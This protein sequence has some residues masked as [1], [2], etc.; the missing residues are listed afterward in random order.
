MATEPWLPIGYVLPD[1]AKLRRT[2]Y[3]D[4]NWQI[5]E[6]HGHGRALVVRKELMQ[7]W[8]SSGLLEE[9]TLAGF[10]YGEQCLWSLS[11]GPSQVLSPVS[12]G[13]SPNTKIEALAFAAALKATRAIDAV[14]PLQDSLYV[15]KYGRLLPTFT[16][17]S[18]ADDDVVL[19]YWLSG[20]APVSALAFRRLNQM[21]SW[22]GPDHLKDVI[23]SAGFTLTET[24]L[25]DTVPSL[26]VNQQT[27]KR[28]GTHQ[29]GRQATGKNAV[30]VLAGRPQLT[31][32]FNEHVID[33][34]KNAER[35]KLL[36]IDFPSAIVLHGPPGCG[37]T[38]AVEKLADYLEW[39][40]FRIDSS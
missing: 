14:S 3:G 27:H 28:P 29:D 10:N 8:A 5:V 6:T 21:L 23:E 20:G 16:I 36:G 15:E 18:Q 40:N 4:F 34:I 25:T 19:G 7:R 35:Y 12:D 30:F 33:I 31:T 1:G 22:I 17:S 13:K 26:V 2:L 9:G 11:S 37:K 32:F 39:P 24:A 38:Y